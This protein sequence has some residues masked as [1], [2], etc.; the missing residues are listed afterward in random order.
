MEQLETGTYEILRNRL[1]NSGDELRQRLNTLNTERKQVFG[2][3]DTRLIGT[4]RITT[5]YNCVAW[6][7]VPVGGQFIFGYN[8]VLGLKAEPD[9]ADVFNVYDYHNQEFRPLGLELLADAKFEEE[10]RN[11]Y[12]YYKHT[13][14][15]KFAV[16]GAHLFMVFRIG[17]GASDVKTFKWLMQGDTLTYLD[18]RSD[19][20]YTFPP[21]HEFAWQRA[22]R[23]M[24]RGGRHPHISIEDKVFVET[25]GGDLTIKVE[26][27]TATGRG[28]LS[29][30]VDDKDQT[31]DDSEIYYAVVG[32][33]VLL[34]IRPYQ[35][36]AY[37]YF[38][39]N[40]K[41]KKAQ[42]LD[43]LADA[44]VLLP[45]GQGLIFPHGFYLQT[46][47][48]KLFDN[49]L[50]DMLFEKRLT[51]PNGEDFLYVFYNKDS[52]LYL[53]LSYNRIAQRVDNPIV[54]HGYAVFENGEL[55]Y[56]R[57][58]EE[59]KKHHA[60]QIWQTPF[61][62]PDFELPVTSDS[63]LYKLG[64]KEIVRAMS[65]VQEVLTLTGKEDSYAGLY[66]D[67]IRQTTALTDT[68]HWL[69]EPA[70]QN[71]AEPLADI[72]QAATA[73][74]EE[75]DKVR[76]IRKSTAEQTQNVF[77]QAAELT[78][79]IRRTAPDD[80][81]G[82]V[83]LLGELRTV[84][85]AVV[86]LKELRYVALPAVEEQA[87]TLETLSQEVA[88]QTV[89]FLLRDDALAPYEQRVQ[90]I[91]DAVEKVQKTV[92]ADE[93]ERETTALAQ[94]LELLIEVVSNLPIP[95]P[96]QTTAIIDRI[97]T[98]YA[99]FNQI[100]ASLK[101]RRQALAGTEAQAQF[102]AQ[103][104]LLEQALTNYLDLADTPAKCDEYLTK[105]M[106][107][108]EELEGRYPDFD[109]FIEQ[110]TTRR[111]QVVEAFEAKKVALVAARNQRAS[112]L[113]QSAERLLKAVQS[114]L[115]RLESVADIGG[116]FASDLMVEKVRQTAREL[117][118]LGD[119]VKADDVQSR[120][121]TLRENAV[122]QL[123]DR[124]DLYAD[125]GQTIRFG[126]YAFTV[127]TQPLELTVVQRDDALFYHLTGTNFF[128]PI[129]DEALLAAR[130]VWDQT[131]VSESPDVYRAEFLAWR[132]LQAAHHPLPADPE[133]GRLAVLSVTD[134]SHL[135][136]AEL[137]SYVQQF[138]AP[139]Y[140][141]GYLKGVHDHDAAKL[142]AALVRLTRTAN[143]LRYPADTRTAAALFWLRFADPA[144]RA[145]WQ[146]QLQGISTL[147]Q[148]FPDS[149]QFD[150]LQAELQTAV[151][152]FAQQTGLFTLDQVQEAGEF[153]FN[154]LIKNGLPTELADIPE[155]VKAKKNDK[156]AQN[157]LSTNHQ[158]LS[159]KNEFP[160][161]QEA[162]ALYRQFQQ[163]LQERRASELFGQSVAALAGQPV[164]QFALVRQWVQAS[165]L[166]P[167]APLSSG[168]GGSQSSADGSASTSK[169][170]STLLSQNEDE[171]LP[172]DSDDTNRQAPPLPE[173]MR[174]E[175][176]RGPG[177]EVA[178]LLLTD[179]FDAA[180][181]VPTPTRE[182]LPG[183]Q[184]THPRLNGTDY[185]LD[186]PAFRRRL[187]HHEQR[188]VPQFEAFQALK[189]QRV[190][191]ATAALRLESFRP[192]VLTSF[193]RNQLIDQ[194]YLPLIGA[195]LA[196]QIGTAGEGKRTDLMG[197]LLLISP[198]GYGKTT[199]MEY[200][201]NRLGL[202]F[203]KIN[204]P[205]IGHSVTS[206]DP[207]QA[208]NAGARQ[209]L[210]K[211]NLA[212]EM[213]DN[214]MIYVDDIQHCHPEFL[215][216]F[217]SLCDAQRQ[218]EGVYRGHP[219]TYDFRGRKVA[220]VMA[221]N[222]YTESG[223]VFQLPDMLANRADI[224]N[225]GDI[226][227]AG[228][229]A[230]FRLSYLENALTSHPTLARLA[231]QSPQDVP[232]LLRLA[233][234]GSAEGLTFEGNHSPEELNEYVAVLRQLLRLRD[235]VARVNAAYIAS[236]AQADAYRTEPP[237]KL[238]GSYRNMNKLAEKVRPV[239]NDQE[240]TDL[241]AA[242][243]A[244]EAQT[245]TSA[246]EANLLKLRELLGW[247]T[248]AETARWQ[249]IKATYQANLRNSGAGQLLQLLDKLEGITGGL[250]GIREVLKG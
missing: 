16:L 189:K 197:L 116:Y 48:N 86:A 148:V 26:N 217:I 239:M 115:A 19:H 144:Q 31:L 222:P 17:K 141:E 21:Q 238:Q 247:Q 225:L 205:A 128:Q 104:K 168:R 171:K 90:T 59:P 18:N 44:C 240:I 176:L 154:S 167:P 10:F 220:V 77:G 177:G 51:S 91:A 184:G 246:T 33:L 136:E 174:M 165:H 40:Y 103:L 215:Q 188:T 229:E 125:G 202:I 89:E 47:D 218:I 38:I 41:L 94:E 169:T 36:A 64:N 162:A 76:A 185:P 39:F 166:T 160:I 102:T 101:R 191:E 249:E 15:V 107:Q 129:E 78:D 226:L 34:K 82:F 70:A 14:F 24:Q 187:L 7:L 183:F 152:H 35:E 74:V 42:R 211:L 196:K 245:L 8:V 2:A 117:L 192:R 137:L 241:L 149:R 4:G 228:S 142:L 138:M 69:R 210:E 109:Q 25:V 66:L 1:R 22:T 9:L 97:S 30:P 85:G 143:L 105:L 60:V 181:I 54:C 200:V 213:G 243:Y 223:D 203:M 75:F 99:R 73:A 158:A 172:N 96:T 155:P 133:A 180:R 150:A 52:G 153:L 227:T 120:L 49:G 219:R 182:I 100:R 232:A 123:R 87:A 126:P 118:A 110:L 6:D 46:G 163:Q 114:R 236:A 81:T 209:E 224:Y 67:L 214:V 145:H 190:A 135:S 146:R 37:R 68:Y 124:A 43:A 250:S 147:L 61:T 112:A 29:E 50:R 216:K 28:I 113:L 134:L 233:E 79:R 151:E 5:E 45:D 98:V 92:E 65:E 83:Q 234:T 121:K 57:T 178:L 106:V 244:S 56:F 161:S 58:D 32:N 156:A 11:L 179:S 207:A 88:Q 201:A 95:D 53:L 72:R 13:Q 175:H 199:L 237:F 195:N 193:V 130:P 212:F 55:C 231:T 27:N 194:V 122:R 63:Y 119:P 131:V 12:R 159:T 173:V 71:M 206:L 242:H 108:L 157:N 198:P 235:V 23:D 221:G 80:V 20:E 93:R 62:G 248:P 186:F 140:A 132:I 170:Q 84:R 3:V 230:A 111:E 164:A 208:P 204:G 139:R 127:N